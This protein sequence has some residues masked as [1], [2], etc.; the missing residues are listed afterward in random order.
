MFI[1]GTNIHGLFVE[2]AQAVLTQ[3]KEGPC[4]NLQ[5]IYESDTKMLCSDKDINN[6]DNKEQ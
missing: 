5:N 4:F 6:K 1:Y 3:R 2:W